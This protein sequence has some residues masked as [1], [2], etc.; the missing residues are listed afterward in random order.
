MAFLSLIYFF[1]DFL[2]EFDTPM[3]DNIDAN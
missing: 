1:F 2:G 3:R